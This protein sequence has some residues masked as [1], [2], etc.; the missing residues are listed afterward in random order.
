[1][2][3]YAV[4]KFGDNFAPCIPKLPQLRIKKVTQSRTITFTRRVD[5]DDQTNSQGHTAGRAGQWQVKI[6][7]QVK[8]SIRNSYPA[9]LPQKWPAEE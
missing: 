3:N 4:S 1:M 8:S 2:F 5:V 6:I 9:L 7:L